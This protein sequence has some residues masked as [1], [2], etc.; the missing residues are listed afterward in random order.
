MHGPAAGH[1]LPAGGALAPPLDAERLRRDFPALDQLI[2]GR[3]LVYLDSAASTQKPRAVLDALMGF[4]ERDYANVHRGVHTLSQRAT[5]AYEGARERV[6]HFLRAEQAEEIVFCR[7]TTEAINLV[8]WAFLAPRLSAG[9]EILLTWLEHHS[10]IV[11]WQL[12]AAATGARLRVVPVNDQGELDLDAF[13]EMLGPQTRLAAFTHISNALG[14]INPV[15]EMCALARDRG[16][17]TLVDGAQAASHCPIDV[18]ALG[19]DFYAFSGH[20]VFGPTG[21]GA[22]YVRWPRFAEMRPYQG[23][24]DMI[25]SVAFAGS[26]WNEPPHRF[27]AGTPNIADAVGLAAALDYVDAIGLEAIALHEAELLAY[28]TA[29]LQAIPGLRLVGT[30]RH[31]AAVLSFTLDGIHPHDAGTILDHEGIAVRAGHHCA[32]PLI[33]RFGLVATLRASLALYN[34][35]Q[36][37]DRLA[38]GLARVDEVFGRSRS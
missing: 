27:E 14:T 5:D 15:R 38:Q 26:E 32:Q 21:I 19:C 20:K 2:H 16:I 10:N 25:R 1:P 22:L 35:R 11:P 29:T 23:G 30:A 9:D 7:G 3:P 24:G 17:P 34:T 4:Y 8:A 13:E 37:I 33:E 36:D 28:G 6:S 18:K 31:K 12:V